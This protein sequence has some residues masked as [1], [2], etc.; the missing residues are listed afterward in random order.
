MQWEKIGRAVMAAGW[1]AV[2]IGCIVV[3]VTRLS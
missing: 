3:L 1:T 2:T